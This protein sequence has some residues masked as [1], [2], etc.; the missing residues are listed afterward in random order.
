MADSCADEG[1]RQV[2]LELTKLSELDVQCIVE[3]AHEMTPTPTAL[4]IQGEI[5]HWSDFYSDLW[6]YSA[7]L[8]WARNWLRD[9]F[10]RHVLD[11]TKIRPV[12][13]DFMMDFENSVLENDWDARQG[14]P[15]GPRRYEN[16]EW[17]KM[18]RSQVYPHHSDVNW[19]EYVSW[20]RGGGGDEWFQ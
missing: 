16:P 1:R 8:V 6:R 13:D 18:I 12:N 4:V 5:K 7:D 9:K 2:L 17:A 20:V 15:T 14:I 3:M 19:R 10:W 11:G